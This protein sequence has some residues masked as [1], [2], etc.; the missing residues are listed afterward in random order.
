MMGWFR[1]KAAKTWNR[2]RE[3]LLAQ[4]MCSNCKWA[5]DDE[6]TNPSLPHPNLGYCL[7]W[8]RFKDIQIDYG[9]A[10]TVDIEWDNFE[11][12][13]LRIKDIKDGWALR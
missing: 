9:Y 10:F 5:I 8:Y 3:P 1:R 12:K 11:V 7:G 13:D 4:R 6:C 2:M